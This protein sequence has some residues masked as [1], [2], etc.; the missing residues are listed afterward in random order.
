MSATPG[1]PAEHRRLRVACK[2]PGVPEIFRSLQGEGRNIGRMRTFIRLS[3]CNLQCFWCD[4][5]YTWNWQGTDWSHADDSPGDR[6]KYSQ[7]AE[8]VNMPV[9]EI[10]A[11]VAAMPAEGVVVTGGE[12]LVQMRG[13][14]DMIRGLKSADPHALI[15]IE[16][17]G[18]IAPSAELVSAVDLF[19][20]SPKLDHAANRDGRALRPSALAAFAALPSASFKF[21]A[22][23]PADIP[24]IAAIAQRYRIPPSRIYIMPLGTTSEA[25]TRT[26]ASLVDSIM[27]HGFSYSDRLHIHLFGDKRGK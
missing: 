16:T 1:R 22:G 14:G 27:A 15:E 25:V 18:T 6:R 10:I 7:A 26:G 20:V 11:R 13:L 23:G 9:A 24:Q 19:M 2:E 8:S 3:G 12:P 21:V 5:P 4:T 17:N